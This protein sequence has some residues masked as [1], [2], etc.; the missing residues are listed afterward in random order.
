MF[1]VGCIHFYQDAAFSRGKGK[2]VKAFQNVPY[3]FG[4]FTVGGP[5]TGK[6]VQR[7][8]GPVPDIVV[9]GVHQILAKGSIGG[10][11]LQ[12]LDMSPDA[13]AG[14]GKLFAGLAGTGGTQAAKVV[15]IRCN[16]TA[17]PE[18]AGFQAHLGK[19]KVMV[20]PF[21][22]RLFGIATGQFFNKCGI[23]IGVNREEKQGQP[24]KRDAAHTQDTFRSGGEFGTFGESLFLT[25]TDLRRERGDFFMRGF[26][27]WLG[28][29]GLGKALHAFGNGGRFGTFGRAGFGIFAGSFGMGF[30]NHAGGLNRDGLRGDPRLGNR[31]TGIQEEGQ[32]DRAPKGE[33]FTPHIRLSVN[34]CPTY[35]IKSIVTRAG[36]KLKF[37]NSLTK[38]RSK[39]S[40]SHLR[41][42]RT[43]VMVYQFMGEQRNEYTV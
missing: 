28:N 31:G 7:G 14:R 24:V 3:F 15:H 12:V 42:G 20:D 9:T 39:V 30:R 41:T 19:G 22:S 6:A 1:R 25:G 18:E 10:I 27:L 17:V 35:T 40:S 29:Y 13:D 5:R 4:I 38:K 8:S 2:G 36:S 21:L 34:Y 16:K 23:T 11:G 32:D 37:W 26:F 33:K 43:A